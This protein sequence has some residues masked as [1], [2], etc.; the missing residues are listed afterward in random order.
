MITI[1]DNIVI[2]NN[3]TILVGFSGGPDSVYL[4]IHLLKA[5]KEHKT[6]NIIAL[7]LDHEW[8]LESKQDAIWC[9][10]FCAKHN[11]TFV[12]KK[13]SE[14]NSTAKYNGSKEELGRKLRRQFF[15]QEAAKH[16]NSYIALA[17]HQDDQLETFFIRLARGT[18]LSGLTG[19]KE[20]TGK[21]IR[22]LLH[23]R[24]QEILTFL[25]DNNI[26]YLEDKTNE[27]MSFLRNR[28][29][30]QL[31]PV[32][33][34]VDDRLST[35]IISTMQQFQKIDTFLDITT[36][37]TIQTITVEKTPL[38]LDTKQFLNLDIIL[39]QRITLSLLINAQATFTPSK[40]L[41]SEVIRFL[42]TG[43]STQHTIH[44]TYQ[45]TKD[46]NSFSIIKR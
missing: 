46:A 31:V 32:L 34:N 42:K 40:A 19:I 44:K 6:T 43:K 24:K 41:F 22:P 12:T 38:S 4:L 25:Q 37:N 21:Y 18:S 15:E 23:M 14:I 17:H 27:D 3:S 30:H 29:R 39:Q 33:E 16:D 5:V 20:V 8:R 2:A 45:V 10:D 11:V 9:Q 7:H 1:S 36:Q 26:S 28:I 35:H 13:A